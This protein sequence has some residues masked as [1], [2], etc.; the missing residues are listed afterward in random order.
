MT[1][2]ISI[3]SI[4]ILIIE[5]TLKIKV[6]GKLDGLVGKGTCQKT[7]ILKFNCSNLKTKEENQLVQAVL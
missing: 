5:L 2:I 4:S 3:N 7:Q 1:A 6:L